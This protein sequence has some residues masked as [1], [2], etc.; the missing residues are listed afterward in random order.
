[1]IMLDRRAVLA[2]LAVTAATASLDLRGLVAH[3]AALAQSRE[4]RVF[5]SNPEAKLLAAMCDRLIPEDEFPSASQAGVIDYIDLQLA[6]E[7]GRG[8]GLY[9]KGP[10]FP[11]KPE[12]G[13]QLPYA[14]ADLYRRALK[15][16]T[17]DGETNF[18]ALPT[19]GRD[20]FLT[21]L[22]KGSRELGDIPGEVFFGI[23]MQNTLEGYF[24]DPIYAGNRD[25]AG[26]RM[27]GFP[28]AYAYYLTEVSRFN[29]VYDRPPYGIGHMPGGSAQAPRNRRFSQT[30]E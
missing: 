19:A 13:Y 27:L 8:A 29:L 21:E 20:A 26:W 10:H 28:G 1:M 3:A 14:P 17:Q 16:I 15:T 23:L 12:Q 11:G 9:S 4:P 5:L 30:G 6:G 18:L 22:Q 2:G 7:W 25:Y 24:A